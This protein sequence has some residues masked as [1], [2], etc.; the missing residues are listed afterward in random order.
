MDDPPN[1]LT[2]EGGRD[3]RGVPYHAEP[4]LSSAQVLKNHPFHIWRTGHTTHARPAQG[5]RPRASEPLLQ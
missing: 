2:S 4:A 3:D 1:E 5:Q